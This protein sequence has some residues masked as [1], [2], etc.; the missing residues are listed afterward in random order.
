MED[1]H[2]L[3]FAS[4]SSFLQEIKLFVTSIRKKYLILADL[5][6]LNSSYWFMHFL[7]G[8]HP[9]VL[10]YIKLC[11]VINVVWLFQLL[12]YRRFR[13]LRIEPLFTT[14]K[15]ALLNA[16]YLLFAAAVLSVFLKLFG[17]SRYHVFGTFI[18]YF[19][20]ECAVLVLVKGVTL[21]SFIKLFQLAK[22]KEGPREPAFVVVFDFA[23]LTFSFF[24]MHLLKYKTVLPNQRAWE[25]LL[26]IVAAWLIT[27]KWTGKFKQTNDN[28]I[29]Y[30]QAPYIKAFYI[31]IAIMSVIVF[32]LGE[33]QHSRTL[34]FGTF[35]LLLALELPYIAIRLKWKRRTGDYDIE[36]VE[37]VRNYIK[38]RELPIDPGVETVTVPA[39]T[40]VRDHFLYGFPNLFDYLAGHIDMQKIDKSRVQ[41]LDTHQLYNI[42]MLEQQQLNLFINL[43]H[44]NNIRWFNK[45]FLEVHSKLRNGGYFIVRTHRLENYREGLERKFPKAVATFIYILHFIWHRAIPKISGVNKLYFTLSRGKNRVVTRAELIGRLHFCGFRF[46]DFKRIGDSHWF[47][48]RKMK[49]PAIDRNPSYGPLIRLRRI[50]YEGKVIQLFKF[51]TMHPYAEYLQDYV[52]ETNKL[53][54]SGKFKDDF[55][56]T[57]WG[58]VMRKYWLDELPQFINYMR[59]DIRILGVRAISQHYFNLYPQDVQELRTQFKPGLVPPYYADLPENFDEIVESERRYLLAKKQAPIKTDVIYFYRAVKNILFHKAHSA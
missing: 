30:A 37:Q 42:R 41:V 57:Q 20:L 26:I 39:H 49:I 24:V 11:L 5:L 16:A 58:K 35:L 19:L 18:L 43:H 46:I 54:D 31:S 27:A 44:I 32:A 53:D 8:P 38:Q 9:N 10:P 23:L 48:A 3:E 51:R 45:Y 40:T 34:V 21:E 36:T 33:F 15:K 4:D 22:R 12:Q 17:F 14:F 56:L 59:G 25:A 52:Y 50:G 6:L 13:H 2:A 47:I 28:N 29:Q 55:R 1:V 7:A